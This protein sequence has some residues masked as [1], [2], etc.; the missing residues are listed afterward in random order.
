M[1][2]T[3]REIRLLTGVF[4]LIVLAIASTPTGPG[5]TC[6]G[7][8]TEEINVTVV[9]N[10]NKNIGA[11]DVLI[12]RPNIVVVFVTRGKGNAVAGTINRPINYGDT[13]KE[14]LK[15][16]FAYMYLA[17]E[18]DWSSLATEEPGKFIGKG[19]ILADDTL[20]IGGKT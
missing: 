2:I 19:I 7:L 17:Y 5:A 12:T 20:Y 14:K 8:P 9:N 16:G 10:Y 4:T 6:C 13:I 11:A 1:K 3:P 18:L 15:G